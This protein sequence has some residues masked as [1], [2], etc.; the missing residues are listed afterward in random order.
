MIN[1]TTLSYAK[2]PDEFEHRHT[3]L[4]RNTVMNEELDVRD[5]E[6][7]QEIDGAKYIGHNTMIDRFG[8]TNS[9][10][11]LSTGAKTLL[12]IR[13]FIKKGRE[14]TPIDI[15]GCGNNV[16]PL[17]VQEVKDKNVNFLTCNYTIACK[18][19]CNIL[20]NGKYKLGSFYELCDLGGKLY[21]TNN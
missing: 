1:L 12:N 19:A 7:I 21:E 20:V 8:N 16:Y 4:F 18:D 3:A 11:Y 9:I 13:W 2:D 17:L 6:I 5:I 14:H 10:K 15:S